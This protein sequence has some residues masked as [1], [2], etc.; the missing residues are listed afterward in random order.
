MEDLK[1]IYIEEA[2]ELLANLETA[3]LS[4]EEN[5]SDSS[6][7]E[8]VFRVMHTLKGNSS[9]FGLTV[10]SDFVHDLETIYDQ[11]R[12][13]LLPLT[14]K[15]LDCTLAA[16]DHLKVIIHDSELEEATNKENHYR[17]I[18]EIAQFLEE[19]NTKKTSS[20]EPLEATDTANLKTYHIFFAPNS[21]IFDDGTN[22]L[23]LL[24]EITTLGKSKTI[25]HF[26]TINS[27]EEFIPT[28]CISSWDIFLETTISFKEVMD[29]FVF[30]QDNSIIEITEIPFTNLI[31]NKQFTEYISNSAN[32][33]IRLDSKEVL[34]L[35][36]SVG[37][38]TSQ[39]KETTIEATALK[40]TKK[41]KE[42]TISSIRIASN[43][44]DELMNLVSELVTTQASLSLY[45]DSNK[46]PELEVISEN[47]EKLSRKL[48]DIAF[49]MT[50]VPINNM[51][52]RF[53]RI[54]RDTS[55]SLGKEINFLTKGGETELDKA[56]IEKLTSPLMHILRNSLDHGIE[57]KKERIKLGKPEIGEI[58]MK[59]YYSGVFVYIQVSD[60]GKG[61]DVEAV[62][63]KA[64]QR[65]LMTKEEQ[66]SDKEIFDFIFHSG[67]STA[68]EVT[69]VSGR[70]VGMDVV[71][72][73]IAEIRGDISIDSFPNKGTTI[74]IK[75][76]L[77]LSIIDGLLVSIGDIKYIVPLSVVVKCYEVENKEM[78]DNFNH[79]L[80]LDGKQVP[81]VNTREE[82]GYDVN[83]EG[84]SQIIVVNDGEQK[85]GISIDFIIDEYQAVIKPQGEYYSNQDFVSGATILGDGT[86]ALV[87]DTHKVIELHKRKREQYEYK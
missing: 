75:L 17:L 85:V 26:K 86:V 4:L 81:F 49:G 61:I 70:G 55:A 48:R 73:N 28:Q 34:I 50:L 1:R 76:P 40:N 77:T 38:T 71:R 64:I 66:L 67:F 32:K 2:N 78:I 79:L 7:I 47:I 59:A 23:F 54:I 83:P 74:S 57:T 5:S 42:K 22:P 52:G 27:I 14:K 84:R 6:H 37:T 20:I 16:L 62:R 72:R 80:I 21:D 18:N 87:L 45:K 36:E 60:D 13:E 19:D 43:K 30:V 51:F 68:K 9:M 46:T 33:A 39:N 31:N 29:V 53:Q 3:L 12:T 56:I 82:F 41:G 63:D 24:S 35:A 65:G 11:V 25:P 69:D 15:L 8:Q 10:V 58:I 44:L